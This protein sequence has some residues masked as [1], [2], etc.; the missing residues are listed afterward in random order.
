MA[1]ANQDYPSNLIE[2]MRRRGKMVITSFGTSM[3]PS[4]PHGAR[5]EIR[6]VALDELQ[7]GDVVLYHHAGQCF[8][9]RL[10]RKDRRLCILKGDSLLT[11]DPPVGWDQ[12]IGRAAVVIEGNA[13]LI[14]LDEPRERRRAALYARFSY[15]ISFSIHVL[16][17][18]CSALPGIRT[19][20]RLDGADRRKS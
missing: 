11:A 15:V 16:G 10:I 12:V 7:I 4:I 3:E 6:P 1:V 19:A 17:I 5:L 2:T 14:P 8:C 9:H 18:L 13:R 20:R